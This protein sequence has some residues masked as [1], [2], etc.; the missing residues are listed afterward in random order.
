[1]MFDKDLNSIYI[2]QTYVYFLLY[3]FCIE[4]ILIN[5]SKD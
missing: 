2:Y 1:M 5:L 4:Y 3:L